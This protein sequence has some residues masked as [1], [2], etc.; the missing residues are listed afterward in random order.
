MF[1]KFL[2]RKSRKPKGSTRK[3]TSSR[4][5]LMPAAVLA[6]AGL[7]VAKRGYTKYKQYKAG[8]ARAQKNAYIKSK[9]SLKARIEQS[10]N[11]TNAPAFKIGTAKKPSFE[12]KVVR[13]TNPPKIFK[14]NYQW[15]AECESGRKGWFGI[16]INSI[17]STNGTLYNDIYTQYTKLT[18]DSGTADPTILS[19]GDNTQQKVYVDYLSEKLQLVNSGSNSL[20]G[21]ISLF[22]YKRDCE[23]TY[24]NVN[25][26]MTPINLMMYASNGSL[27]Q[28]GT[29]QEATVGNGFKFDTTTNGVNYTASYDMPGSTLN[30][31]GATA[32]TDLTLKVN[33]SQIKDFTKYFFE[34][35]KQFDFSLKPGQ[36]INHYT[37]FND[38]PIISRQSIDMAYVRGVSYYLVIQFQAGVVG[39]STANNVIST[40]SGQLSCV[41]EEKRILGCMTK[42]RNQ[43]TM[44]TAPLSGIA[45]A[46]Q[47]IINPD[48]GVA[49]TGYEEDA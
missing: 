42:M 49:D 19:S 20:T 34:E 24:V 10:D 7:A 31:G 1:K 26:P 47:Y 45:K 13:I 48:T 8:V 43:V 12:E 16:P 14:R 18:T 38:L 6:G 3:K 25:A 35:V 28:Y 39:D 21:T 32:Q 29:S 40:G 15:S 23:S 36:Q 11:I 5:K 22:R 30:A 9:A 17:N 44:I 37:I 33:S 46:N 41:L 4:R 27:I 2:F